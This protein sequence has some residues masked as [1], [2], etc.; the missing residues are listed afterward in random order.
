[1]AINKVSIQNISVFDDMTIELSDGIN[2]F[3]GENGTGKTHLLKILY[4]FCET[5]TSDDE[6]YE[7]IFFS[8]F[9][10]Y[11]GS[12]IRISESTHLNVVFKIEA[13][14]YELPLCIW[15]RGL[16]DPMYCKGMQKNKLNSILIPAK[17]MLTHSKGF[18]SLYNASKISFDKSYYDIISK[19]L[20]PEARHTPELAVNILPILE[21]IIDGV[22]VVEN[23]TFYIK[24]TDGKKIEFSV[25]AEGIKKIGLLCQLLVN[26]SITKDSVLFWD[27]PEANINPKLIPDIVDILF[28]LSKQGVQIFVATHDYVFAK[29]FELKRKESS[30]VLFHSLYKTEKGVSCESSESFRDLKNN[31][32]VKAFD[33]LMDEVIDRNLGE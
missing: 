23:E 8:K 1:M 17:D 2:I 33:V 3:I 6:C 22:V 14:S 31:P 7:F 15:N 21:R 16:C 25:E 29:Y 32:I 13:K 4:S 19:A 24:R 26:E 10:D 5:E 18:M 11:F 30:D 27:E 20:L 12:N 28:E 9:N